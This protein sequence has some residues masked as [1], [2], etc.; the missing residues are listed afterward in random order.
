MDPVNDYLTHGPKP[1]VFF[2]YWQYCNTLGSVNEKF[3]DTTF[4][5]MWGGVKPHWFLSP[6]PV[7]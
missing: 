1:C 4:L 2:T 5:L 3:R 7:K 6:V